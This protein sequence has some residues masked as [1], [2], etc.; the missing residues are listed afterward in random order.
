[1]GRVMHFDVVVRDVDRASAFYE[2]AFGWKIEKWDGPMD[3]WL[4]ST[5][6]AASPGIDGGM[7][8]GEPNFTEGPLTLDVDSLDNALAAVKK[9][10][11]SQKGERQPVPGVGYMATVED[12]EGNRWGLM[13]MDNNA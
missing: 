2:N 13:E 4:I 9:A 7:S 6:D 11:G 12:P 8:V 3:Y 5:G 1:M 10:G